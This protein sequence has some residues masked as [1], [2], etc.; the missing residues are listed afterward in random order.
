MTFEEALRPIPSAAET[1]A[2]FPF[3]GAHEPRLADLYGDPV[4]HALMRR[5]G[6]DLCTLKAVVNAAQKRLAA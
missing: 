1:G 3:A 5:D 2:A 4:L 6:I